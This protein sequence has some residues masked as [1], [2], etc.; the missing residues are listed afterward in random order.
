MLPIATTYSGYLKAEFIFVEHNFYYSLALLARYPHTS[1]TTQRKY[2]K[3][4]AENQK[5]MRYWA[6]HA[7]MNFQHLYDLVE[8][9]KACVL[10]E[11][12]SAM[13]HYDCAIAGSKKHEYIQYEALA[14][15]LAA[16][17]G[18]A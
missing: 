8:A 6:D 9:E 11:P 16:N 3:Q 7:P 17:F 4:V 13:K 18:V 5:M 14:N 1:Q 10:D 2:L 12:F 15:E